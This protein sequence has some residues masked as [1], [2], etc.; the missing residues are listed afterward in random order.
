MLKLQ[1]TTGGEVMKPIHQGR[2][3]KRGSDTTFTTHITIP[4]LG[5]TTGGTYSTTMTIGFTIF[6]GPGD[7][8]SNTV[9]RRSERLPNRASH[10]GRWDHRSLP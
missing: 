9:W 7:W 3:L 4:C 2:I 6:G 10:G 5:E 8:Q 1:I